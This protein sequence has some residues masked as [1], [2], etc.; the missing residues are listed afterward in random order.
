MP[1]V[2]ERNDQRRDANKCRRPWTV[3]TMTTMARDWPGHS[4]ESLLGTRKGQ[5]SSSFWPCDF[6]LD[7]P[8][9]AQ[10]RRL[11]PDCDQRSSQLGRRRSDWVE[12]PRKWRSGP[13]C[14]HEGESVRR[15]AGSCWTT[16][17]FRRNGL[18]RYRRV[19]R[20]ECWHRPRGW[21]DR[22]E[23]RAFLAPSS[24][25]RR[26]RSTA[27]TIRVDI[28]TTVLPTHPQRE[29]AHTDPRTTWAPEGVPG[30][31]C[32]GC[33][34]KRRSRRGLDRLPDSINGRKSRRNR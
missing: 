4:P 14:P 10:L 11:S 23:G 5:P 30:H 6:G 25:L 16:R 2:Q 19:S 12:C 33:D 8:G 26:K 24:V 3:Q 21:S 1:C 28:L 32:S 27:D 22:V 29:G 18:S 15:R 7:Q 31:I 20:H 13:V 9:D 17:S 34:G